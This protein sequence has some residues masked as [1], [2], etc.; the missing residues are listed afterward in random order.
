MGERIR[1]L[2]VFYDEI[3]FRYVNEFS[4]IMLT[5]LLNHG[6]TQLELV[7]NHILESEPDSTK[8][9][10]PKTNSKVT[11]ESL[12]EVEA[13]FQSCMEMLRKVL[14]TPNS[15]NLDHQDEKNMSDIMGEWMR[16]A[17][18]SKSSDSLIEDP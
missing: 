15:N 11:M 12:D 2:K 14:L 16:S 4:E 9:T 13:W 18:K 8:D 3:Y 5:A 1:R 6:V 7:R 17:G 10:S